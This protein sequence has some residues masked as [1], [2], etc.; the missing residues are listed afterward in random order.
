MSDFEYQIPETYEEAVARK[1]EVLKLIN[2]YNEALLLEKELPCTEEEIDRL[3]EEYQ[4]LNDHLALTDEER[5]EKLKDSDKEVNEDGVVVEKISVL[6]KIH[7]GV[8]LYIVFTFIALCSMPFLTKPVGQA[9]INSF[10]SKYLYD[11][12]WEKQIGMF[13]L[14]KSEFMLTAGTYW[15]R[16]ALY[17][18]WLPLLLIVISVAVYLV[19]YFLNHKKNDLNTKITKWLIFVNIFIAVLSVGIVL[20]QGEFKVLAERFE[21][22]WYEYA[23]Y[24]NSEIGSY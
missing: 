7:W 12:L 2:E 10:I 1:A 11:C 20:L 17:Y 16:V 19:V 13:E 15:F 18:L 22:L 8:L 23:I 3:Q 14:E 5:L 6:D 24:Y 4:I 9:G 21:L